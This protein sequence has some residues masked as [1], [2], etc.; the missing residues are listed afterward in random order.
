[1][2]QHHNE[3]ASGRR[4]GVLDR[5]LRLFSEVKPG[6]ATTVLLMLFNIFLILVCYYVI[7]TIREPLILATGGAEVKSYAAAGQA[8]VLMLFIPIYGWF[9]SR[10]D[11]VKLV[12][13]VTLFFVLNIELFSLA[14]GAEFAYVGVVFF[15]WVGFFSLTIIAQFWSYANDIYSKDAGNRL[16]PIIGIGMTAGAP[17]GAALAERLFNDGIAPHL[18]LH[19]SAVLLL[20]TLGLYLA[21]NG[22]ETR[23]VTDST[24]SQEAL[25][26]GNGFALVL[27]SRYLRYIA[28]LFILLNLVNTTGE[29]LIGKLIIS[30]ADSALASGLAA[31]KGAFIGAFYGNYYFWVNIVAVS[32]QALVVSRIVKYTG[33]RGV[34]L[35]LPF[36]SLGAYGLI[37][38]GI[39]FSA[40]RWAKTAENSTDY[41]VMN[42][43]RQLLWLPTSREEK[44]KAKQ[45]V[46]TFIVRF[47]D[48]LSAGFVFAGTTWLGLDITGFAAGNIGIVLLWLGV[49][50]LILKEHRKLSQATK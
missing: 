17:V 28:L 13:G 9:S 40:V 48:V 50:F 7:K 14:V 23:R 22:R 31:D 32:L 4:A 30:E 35:L 42:T 46:D 29:Y 25:A 41:S 26:P 11:R 21:V 19:I 36:I 15:I 5:I 45:T 10:V 8:L 38:A 34:L 1:M 2:S 47:G 12:V 44:Y 24:A 16:F 27:R 39:G 33:L 20:V 49:A 37:A 6:E 18:M 43:A 3:I